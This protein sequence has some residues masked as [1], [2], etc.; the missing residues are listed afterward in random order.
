MRF[1]S[2][3]LE[4]ARRSSRHITRTRFRFRSVAT[5]VIY[6]S[7]R[8]EIARLFLK[9]DNTI[10]TIDVSRVQSKKKKTFKTLHSKYSILLNQ[11]ILGITCS[12]FY[13]KYWIEKTPYYP[14]VS[15]NVLFSLA[16]I[17]DAVSKE[18]DQKIY[19]KKKTEKIFKSNSKNKIQNNNFINTYYYYY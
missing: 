17:T 9:R 4:S 5:R 16:A 18:I 2:S 1:V 14:F 8:R 3:N 7:G 10:N 19:S 13:S 15:N 11:Y 12:Y 6:V